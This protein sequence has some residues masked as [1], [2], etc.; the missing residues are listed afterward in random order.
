MKLELDPR[1]MLI[2][3]MRAWAYENVIGKHF[4]Y[5][6]VYADEILASYDHVMA[7]KPREGAGYW[8]GF[9]F[10]RFV[11]KLENYNG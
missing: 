4:H 5:A 2:V 11:E 9:Y 3:R 10:R 7:V 6:E 8:G 1:E